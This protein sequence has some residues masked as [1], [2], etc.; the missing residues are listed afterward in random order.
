MSWIWWWGQ[1]GL[2]SFFFSET[3]Q[4]R[5]HWPESSW[6]WSN[7]L[8]REV[9][10]GFDLCSHLNLNLV[11]VNLP[12]Q[13][14]VNVSL[15]F[16]SRSCT[17][18]T[19]LWSLLSVERGIGGK[20]WGYTLHLTS[21]YHESPLLLKGQPDICVENEFTLKCWQEAIGVNSSATSSSPSSSTSKSIH[22]QTR[23]QAKNN[24]DGWKWRKA[25]RRRERC[26]YERGGGAPHPCGGT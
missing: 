23:G 20:T 7:G 15:H 17:N 13:G 4:V 18:S 2:F 6:T 26:Y 10:P 5:W 12:R 3:F 24:D 9:C 8:C 16:R 11:N 21:V 22:T 14:Q 25:R 19:R 1:W